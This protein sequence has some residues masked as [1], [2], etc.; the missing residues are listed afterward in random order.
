MLFEKQPL[1]DFPDRAFREALK[2]RRNLRDVV[3]EALP[4]LAEPVKF[5]A[6]LKGWEGTR[7]LFFADEA[8]G[9]AAAAAFS[10]HQGPAA[11]FTGPEGGF[12]DAERGGQIEI[13]LRAVPLG[14]AWAIGRHRERRVAE[15]VMR[16]GRQIRT[17]H[18]AAERHD[19]RS[20]FGEQ[21]PQRLF[22]RVG[23]RAHLVQGHIRGYCNS[24]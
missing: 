13:R 19:R 5:D 3:R 24:R 6:L 18:A 20:H 15:D 17:V 8:G 16:D 23:C 21:V 2:D 12:D 4:E 1:H 7:A 14:I 9:D 10:A 11:L 22:L